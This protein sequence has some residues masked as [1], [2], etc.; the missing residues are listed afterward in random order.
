MK[1][2]CLPRSFFQLSSRFVYVL[3]RVAAFRRSW[4][5]KPASKQADVRS[6]FL[7]DPPILWP[8]DFTTIE[9]EWLIDLSFPT[10]RS[11]NKKKHSHWKTCNAN[12]LIYLVTKW[13][14]SILCLTNRGKTDSE[15]E[16]VEANPCLDQQ[17][18]EK[19]RYEMSQIISENCPLFACRCFQLT[20]ESFLYLEA[21]CKEKKNITSCRGPI[22]LVN[23]QHNYIIIHSHTADTEN[24]SKSWH[25][26]QEK[27]ILNFKLFK[28][29]SSQGAIL[30]PI[31]IW[32][33]KFPLPFFVV[34]LE[35]FLVMG[36]RR[37]ARKER[38]WQIIEG[39]QVVPQP[40][41]L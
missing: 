28:N 27:T 26:S 7:L 24:L 15:K 2:I 9:T 37:R 18:A 17:T 8:M 20:P 6:L 3:C 19:L 10:W 30:W 12:D 14:N 38:L 21:R 16:Q 32:G 25:I 31:S 4:P 1:S 35:S 13:K 22:R 36:Q 39:I 40:D 23:H 11:E 29:S 41:R 33:V 34:R 5:S